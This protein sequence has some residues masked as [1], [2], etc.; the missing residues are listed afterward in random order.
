MPNSIEVA[1]QALE[2]G[3][4][5][6]VRTDGTMVANNAFVTGTL[7]IPDTAVIG[8]FNISKNALNS[9]ALSIT[10]NKVNIASYKPLILGRNFNLI[11]TQDSI[12][13]KDGSGSTTTKKVWKSKIS[14][15]DP[16][17]I[18]GENSLL[19]SN[20]IVLNKTDTDTQTESDTQSAAENTE[21]TKNLNASI[22]LETIAGKGSSTSSQEIWVSTTKGVSFVNSPGSSGSATFVIQRPSPDKYFEEYG[23]GGGVSTIYT[24][25]AT[26]TATV[27]TGSEEATAQEAYKITVY[28]KFGTTWY[29]TTLAIPKDQKTASTTVSMSSSS[30]NPVYY[31]ISA[32][33][34]SYASIGTDV[35]KYT[36]YYTTNAVTYTPKI[37]ANGDLTVAGNIY[38]DAFYASSDRDLKTNIEPINLDYNLDKFYRQL[39]PVKFN[40][41]TDLNARHFG[42]IAQDLNDTLSII[43]TDNTAY[44]IVTKDDKTGYY[45]VN[46]NEMVALNA[47]QIKNIMNY[48]KDL[49]SQYEALKLKYKELE[50]KINENR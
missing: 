30:S 49:Q 35:L 16:L 22:L 7:N 11:S 21:Q 42:F 39:Q 6:K 23:S 17:E 34:S 37:T 47:A 27:Y 25:K 41:K 44:S 48:I 43:S 40:F 8:G 31:G 9:P 14:S 29:S 24:T 46:Y 4:N 50:E 45:K 19:I 13:T 33:T 20:N 10:N 26:I 36:R 5:F 2:I 28:Y 3:T 38:G 12:S 1:L 15:Q 18:L 32:S